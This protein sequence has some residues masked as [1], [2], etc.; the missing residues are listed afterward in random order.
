MV[1][2]LIYIV[3]R[4]TY[5]EWFADKSRYPVVEIKDFTSFHIKEHKIQLFQVSHSYRKSIS[6]KGKLYVHLLFYKT[7]ILH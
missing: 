3:L 2:K 1:L 7:C 6:I 5:N 4:A